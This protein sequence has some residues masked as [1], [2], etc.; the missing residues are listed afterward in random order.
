MV[1]GRVHAGLLGE[2]ALWIDQAILLETLGLP[3]LP[4]GFPA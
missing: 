2:E 4:K 3:F 1:L